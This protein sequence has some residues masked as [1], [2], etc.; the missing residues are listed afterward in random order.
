MLPFWFLSNSQYK[1]TNQTE[2]VFF[3]FD[4]SQNEE[5]VAL[6]IEL[7]QQHINLGIRNHHYLLLLLARQ[8]LNDHKKGLSKKECGWIDKDLLSS[9]LGQN[10]NH[11]NIQIYRFRKQLLKAC[12]SAKQGPQFVER[13]TGEIRFSSEKIQIIGGIDMATASNY[14]ESNLTNA[15]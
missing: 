9:M 7:Q 1:I 2:E 5:H 3:K 14:D 6:Q 10:E 4:V 12:P 11:I 15:I 8:Y 13:R